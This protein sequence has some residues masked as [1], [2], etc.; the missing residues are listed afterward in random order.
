M[1]D[2]FSLKSKA[3]VIFGGAGYIGRTLTRAVLE[4]GG[5]VIVADQNGE[6]FKAGEYAGLAG[7]N[8]HFVSCNVAKADEIRAVY[9]A[10]VERYGFMNAMINLV[11]YGKFA[12]ITKQG[13]EDMAFSLDGV[14]GQ[15]FRTIREAIPYLKDRGGAIVTT[16]SMYG[17][18]S[19]DYRI[20]GNSGQ[21]N[22]PLYGMG[23]A[24]VIQ[25]TRYA[26]AHLASMGIRVN[27]V[28]PG[29]VPDP[30]K[31]PPKEFMEQLAGKTMLG[32]VGKPE[33]MA[34]AFIYLIS[35]ASAF[36]TGECIC[37]DGGWTKW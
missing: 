32:R 3:I 23:K 33:D 6:V 9:E 34:G 2:L 5:R 21:N 7:D 18:V 15:V 36:T 27:S 22:P 8:F 37:V 17:I 10:C 25:L 16:A 4:Q 20:Y 12:D 19:P 14:A 30:V 26:A 13:D 28:S 24:A 31:N 29:P 1:T 11:A 35:D